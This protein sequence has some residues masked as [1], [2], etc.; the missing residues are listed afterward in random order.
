MMYIYINKAVIALCGSWQTMVPQTIMWL[1]IMAMISQTIMWL[2]IMAD[3]GPPNNH[4]TGDH[5][6]GRSPKQSADCR[7]WQTILSPDS[8]VT[9]DHDKTTII[10]P[11]IR[12][13]LLAD[14]GKTV[15]VSWQTMN[16]PSDN[17][18]TSRPNRQWSHTLP[19]DCRS[20]QEYVMADNGS[21]DQAVTACRSW[22][23]C[24][25]AMQWIGA[26]Q[27]GN[28]P[29]HCLV[30]ADHGKTVSWQTIAH[31]TMQWIGAD[32]IDNG[33]ADCLVT[34]DHGKNTS[35]QTIAPSDNAVTALC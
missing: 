31:Q 4:V 21:S 34:E 24:V 2:Q 17:T 22:Q 19:C 25:I 5:G 35:W 6:N 14:H 30:T 20:W 10:A 8:P 7:S 32:Q 12:L 29:A 11:Q 18:V 28:G 15:S 1:Q 27:I 9:A 13:W 33:P 16:S 23:D 3:N 26:D